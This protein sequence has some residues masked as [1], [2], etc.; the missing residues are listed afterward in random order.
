MSS[1]RCG[2][3]ALALGCTTTV[4]WQGTTVRYFTN[5]AWRVRGCTY[6]GRVEGASLLVGGTGA[7]NARNEMREQVARMGGSDLNI[8]SEDP[9]ASGTRSTGEAYLC[10]ARP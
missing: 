8:L 9:L 10:P 1:L 2:L 6:L 4:S 5:D 7:L 3:L